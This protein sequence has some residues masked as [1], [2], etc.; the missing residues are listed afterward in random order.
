[1]IQPA[2]IPRAWLALA[3][4]GVLCAGQAS[5]QASASC[6]IAF[7]MGSSGIRAGASHSAQ[8][9]RAQIDF[10][11]PASAGHLEDAAPAAIAALQDLPREGGFE[12]Q[13]ARVGGGFSV[14][15]LALSQ[16]ADRLAT[17]L[18]RI[19]AA[20]GVAVLVMPQ[21]AEGAYGY[22][23]ARQALGARLQTSHILDIGGGSL[24]IAGASTSFGEA[25]GQKSWHRQLCLALR[26]TDAQPCTLQPL[27][28]EELAA[29]RALLAQ[30]LRGVNEALQGPVTLTAISRP[31]T[32]GIVPALQALRGLDTPPETLQPSDITAAIEHLASPPRAPTAPC[33][34]PAPAPP[35]Y[36]LSDLLLLEGLL[37]ATGNGLL[38]VADADLTNLPGLLADDR[39][40]DWSRHYS[41]YLDR[42]REQGLPAYDSDPA[43]CPAPAEPR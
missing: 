10:F 36:L 34:A 26:H 1:M 33:A 5:A 39:A 16:D 2:R 29:A 42:L 20:S 7:D 19:H 43:T 37:Q 12:P 21:H 40:F 27:S 18:A 15:R 6:R 3:L 23:G 31:V 11:A 13:C 25:L 32:R 35:A 41:C 28:R 14:W 8:V 17:T 4:A 9:T 38:R 22:A 30:Q 24:Q